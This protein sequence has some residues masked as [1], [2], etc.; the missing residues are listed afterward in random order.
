MTRQSTPTTSQRASAEMHLS[1]RHQWR[2]VRSKATGVAFV[3]MPSSDGS[4]VYQVHPEARACSCKWYTV[5]NAI[6][7]HMLA[8]TQAHE[9]DRAAAAL[10]DDLRDTG[11]LSDGEVDLLFT[12]AFAGAL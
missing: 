4:R 11:V 10:E 5:G 9:E 8:L 3:V 6:C 1:R 12:I 7:S 2:Y